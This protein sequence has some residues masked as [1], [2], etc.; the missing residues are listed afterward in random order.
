MSQTKI[1]FILGKYPDPRLQNRISTEKKVG[2]VSLICWDM[3]SVNFDFLDDE[4]DIYPIKI[5]ANRTNPLKRL[6]PTIIFAVK[7]Q[8]RLFKISPQIL[9]VE[10]VDMLFVAFLYYLFR[11]DKPKIIYEVAD[12]HGLIINN[13]KSSGR[14]FIKWILIKLEKYLCKKISILILTSNKFYEVYYRG[15]VSREKVLFIPNIPNL[16]AFSNY[17]KKQGGKFTIGFIGAVRYKEQMK[18][19]IDAA[20]GKGVDILIAGFA[21]DREIEAYCANKRYVIFYGK[22][23]Y[24]KDIANIYGQVDCVYSVYNADDNN[25]K[26]ALPNKLYEAVYCELPIIVAKGTYLSELV[27]RMGIGITVSHKSITDLENIIERISTDR[28]YY[29]RFVEACRK[30]K[31]DIDREKYDLKLLSK[32][33]G[34]LQVKGESK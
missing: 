22:Y 11:R 4:V 20:E 2:R 5:K 8:K 33:N 13:P 9:H 27:E 23:D 6:L 25:V 29:E 17:R 28:E 15:F 3:G 14:K 34:I 31:S 16:A 19:L 21:F 18:L 32:I 10:N 24:N 12:L 26:V 1:T 7:A 30:H